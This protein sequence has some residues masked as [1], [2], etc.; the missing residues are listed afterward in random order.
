VTPRIVALH[1]VPTSPTLWSRVPLHI[2]APALGGVATV[3]D[4]GDWSLASFVDEVVPLLDADT[5]LIGHDLGGVV[6][7]MAAMRV[8]VR[9]LVLTGTALGP[10]WGP[11]RLT[12]RAPL[13]HYFYDRYG[14]RRFLAGGVAPALSEDV[15]AAFPPVP[16]VAARMRALARE[17][18][19]PP[20]LARAVA[21]RVPVSLVWGRDDRWYPPWVAGAVAR[22]T[23]AS[24]TWVD[25]GHLCMWEEPE[26]YARGLTALL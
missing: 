23:G 16:D 13:H 7:A 14:G 20:G 11:V 12:A 18:C 10:Y 4:R 21:A 22:G 5:V 15:L 8:R 19:P 3:A 26:A 6:A 17:M 1:G 24:I 9:R 25:G 2:V